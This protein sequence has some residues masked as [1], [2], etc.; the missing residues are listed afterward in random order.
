MELKEIVAVTGVS[1]LK[2][3]V[4]NRNDG[5]ILSDLDGANKKF[6]PSRTHLFSPLDNISI[7]TDEDMVTVGQ[8]FTIM[9]KNEA[10]IPV[11]DCN[12][13]NEDLKAYMAAI[14]PNY[15]RE[16]VKISDIKKLVKWYEFVKPYDVIGD[17][18]DNN[19]QLSDD[20]PQSAE[21][22]VDD[23]LPSAENTANDPSTND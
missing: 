17:D 8:V 19:E 20:T 3:L 18:N 1:G 2:K 14:L 16:K 10:A 7:Y 23:S 5:L 9:K 22:S 6:Y 11:I 15:D 12:A 21:A 4:A 13:S